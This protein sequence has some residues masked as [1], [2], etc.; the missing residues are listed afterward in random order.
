MQI[1][2]QK[3]KVKINT[4]IKRTK[5]L[6]IYSSRKVFL[7]I[8]KYLEVSSKKL[9]ETVKIGM[10]TNIEINNELKNHILKFLNI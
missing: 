9:I 2:L 4:P 6:K 5:E 1:Q 8:S 3:K 10:I 7:R